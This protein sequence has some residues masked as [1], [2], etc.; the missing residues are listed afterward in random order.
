[1]SD[2]DVLEVH[3]DFAVW[4]STVAIGDDSDRRQARWKGVDKL[5]SDCDSSWIE[6]LIRCALETKTAASPE[7]L[8]K[9]RQ[10]FK[11]TDETYDLSGNA[12]EL[13][14][15]AA[16]ALAV[17]MEYECSE[18][19]VASLSLST[20]SSSKARSA[21]LPM[22]LFA[23]A[24]ISIAR[25]ADRNRLRPTL[26][27]FSL[28]LTKVSFAAAA[29]KLQETQSFEGAGAA[30]TIAGNITKT[31][32][33]KVVTATSTS[34]RQF[35]KYLTIQDEELQM[36]WWL[37]GQRSIDLD[38][39]HEA[40]PN[41]A[42]PFVFAR[43]LASITTTLPGPKSIKALFSR[44]GLSDRK[45]IK[46][47]TAVNGCDADWLQRFFNDLEPSPVTQPLHFAIKRQ[48]ETGAS[49]VWVGPWEKI[50]NISAQHSLSQIELANLFYREHLLF[51]VE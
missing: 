19:S 38:C 50:T 35:D 27:P 32:L 42:K 41:D 3:P 21:K 14:V 16:A 48:L 17:L 29:Q 40:V 4:Y 44:A 18:A 12:R 39:T 33:G 13:A 6:S 22:D 8:Q 7:I 46:I 28:N 49:D 36:L 24:E 9:I 31:E 26:E 25:E 43:E 11:D 15:L 51:Q 20:F 5:V 37:L 2:E 1:M 30:L 34:L 23:L 10:C 47:P 45:K